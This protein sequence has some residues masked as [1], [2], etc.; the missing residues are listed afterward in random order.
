MDPLLSISNLFASV[1][2]TPILK[3]FS[4]SIEPGEIHVIMGPNGTG[5]STLG[6]ILA[7]HPEYTVESGEILFCGRDLLSLS[8]EERSHLG[9][10][11]GFQ[12]PIEVPGVTTRSFLRAALRAQKKAIGE[13]FGDKECD[14]VLTEKLALLG[15]NQKDLDREINS[16]C[17]GGEKKRNEIL[18]MAILEPHLALL[19]EADSGLDID[20]LKIV[21]HGIKTVMKDKV[22][23]LITHYQRLLDYIRPDCV[24]VM[25]GGRIVESGG[26]CLASYL[27]EHGYDWLKVGVS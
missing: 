1:G 10:F 22:I 18:Q 13:E 8:P 24:H 15:M 25:I 27:E 19:D 14:Q 12:H 26:P 2:S 6:K 23:L 7:G 17:S 5:K 4:L 16:G 20:A 9:L 11:L 3:N 21:S